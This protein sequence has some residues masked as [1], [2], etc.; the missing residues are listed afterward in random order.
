MLLRL[1]AT[2]TLAVLQILLGSFA[3][4]FAGTF[5]TKKTYTEP[6]TPGYHLPGGCQ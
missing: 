4:G 3:V 5:V 6:L 1:V 2:K